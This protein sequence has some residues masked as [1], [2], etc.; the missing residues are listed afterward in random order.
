[1]LIGLK[2]YTPAV[3]IWSL[4]VAAYYRFFGQKPLRKNCSAA[5]IEAVVELVGFQPFVTMYFKYRPE[6]DL[7]IIDRLLTV[8]G[9][10]GT[11]EH[12]FS[13]QKG[14]DPETIALR[15]LLRRMLE[16]DPDIRATA[17]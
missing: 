3:D 8:A 14:D 1:M 5:T 11:L 6:A 17:S 16:V 7:D 4:G 12:H 9:R 10:K 13:S 15:K 2:Y